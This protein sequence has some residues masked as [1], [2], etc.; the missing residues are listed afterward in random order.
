MDMK[1]ASGLTAYVY[2]AG[3]TGKSYFTVSIEGKGKVA[4]RATWHTVQQILR[5][6]WYHYGIAERHTSE[7]ERGSTWNTFTIK[8]R[9]VSRVIQSIT[10]RITTETRIIQSWLW[11]G[12]FRSISATDGLPASVSR[13]STNVGNTQNACLWHITPRKHKSSHPINQ[14]V[15]NSGLFY[16]HYALFMPIKW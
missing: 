15:S 7:S 11:I 4:T 6:N 13:Q 10:S 3:S 12:T 8:W 2:P 16:A 14:T 1:T 9:Q 5:N